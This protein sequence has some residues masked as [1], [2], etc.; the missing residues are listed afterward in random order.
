MSLVISRQ[1]TADC[2]AWGADSAPYNGRL[3][4]NRRL[5][6]QKNGGASSTKTPTNRSHL[7]R[8]MRLICGGKPTS[9]VAHVTDS[10]VAHV[11]DSHVAHVIDSHVAH[12][13]IT[14]VGHVI[15]SHV[16]HV[17]ITHVA[18]VSA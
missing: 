8:E 6:Q 16:G 15:D 10:H 17:R 13:R 7:R 12:V 9:H 11:I 14:H 2:S 1:S 18:H 3:T 5:I 4:Q